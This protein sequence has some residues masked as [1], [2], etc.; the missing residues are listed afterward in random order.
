M[1]GHFE[2]AVARN[3]MR[4]GAVLVAL[5]LAAVPV[6]TRA[7]TKDQMIADW[8]RHR[9]LVLA[10]VDAMPDSAISFQPTADARPFAVVIE[11]LADVDADVAARAIRGVPV[12]FIA[13]TAQTLHQKAALRAHVAQSL[14][15]VLDAVRGATPAQLARM[16]SLDGISRSGARWLASAQEQTIWTLGTCVEYLRMNGVTSPGYIPM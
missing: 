5:S 8:T 6:A 12:P 2:D 1:S 15:Y 16:V 14:D 9:A 7:Q 13:D 3:E 4:I 11:H 10:F